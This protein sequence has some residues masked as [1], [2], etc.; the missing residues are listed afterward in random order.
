MT[1]ATGLYSRNQIANH[2]SSVLKLNQHV[3]SSLSSFSR[4]NYTDISLSYYDL[5]LRLQRSNV[6]FLLNESMQAL[7]P[8]EV[9]DGSVGGVSGNP[10]W[11]GVNSCLSFSS[12]D[13]LSYF[14]YAKSDFSIVNNSFT[15]VSPPIVLLKCNLGDFIDASNNFSFVSYDLSNG[16]FSL[17]QYSQGIN[18]SFLVNPDPSYLQIIDISFSAV[19]NALLHFDF[20]MFF[21]TQEYY[22]DISH[23]VIGY[24]FFDI[25]NTVDTVHDYLYDLN[26]NSVL[27]GLIFSQYLLSILI[28]VSLPLLTVRPKY[29]RNGNLNG[30]N[31]TFTMYHGN[32]SGSDFIVPFVSTASIVNVGGVDSYFY[33]ITDKT[34]LIQDITNSFNI[35]QAYNHYP[36]NGSSLS[37]GDTTNSGAPLYL[38]MNVSLFLSQNDFSVSLYDSITGLG[39]S[40]SWVTNFGFSS[41]PYPLE[42]YY[43]TG[44]TF[45]EI[46][47]SRIINV[48]DLYLDLT[49][50]FFYIRPFSNSNGLYTTVTGEYPGYYYNDIRIEIP[51]GYYN[52]SSLIAAMNQALASN[53]LTALSSFLYYPTNV[54]NNNPQYAVMKIL[55][56]KTFTAADYVLDF[57]DVN[58]FYKCY[59]LDESIRNTTWDTT[60]GWILGYRSIQY[61]LSNYS[62]SNGSS[63]FVAKIT[64]DV[65]VNVNLFSYFLITVDDFNQSRL[66]DGLVSITK[67]EN[68]IPLPNYSSQYEVVCPTKYGFKSGSTFVN[69]QNITL[70][71]LYASIQVQ[72]SLNTPISKSYSQGPFVKDIFGIIPLKT[73]GL[74]TGQVFSDYGGS[75][76][77][78]ERLY[79]GPVNIRRLK[80]QLFNNQ[81]NLVDLNGADWSFSFVCEQL[82]QINNA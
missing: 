44:N 55:V 33:T 2:F 46:T 71:K 1:L 48:T 7:F 47:G 34:V 22:V 63:H 38:N 30:N 72:N 80:I 24:L 18:R 74:Q 35:F 23:S 81:G 59:N 78:Q 50:N 43:V 42:Q 56:S 57:Y 76:Q 10:I 41:S 6:P 39:N 49:S 32:Y 40:S 73:A 25:N 13:S 4:I 54:V 14:N 52:T 51:V 19:T 60:L 82:Y 26:A 11:T 21:K 36:L 5:T 65:T 69:Q 66:N 29:K 68:D 64:G 37:F 8:T 31:A 70:N 12:D 62:A 77:Q 28:P 79:F 75:L 67:M 27:S 53:P 20:N 3:S 15:I 45:T 58:S 9:V 16:S 17:S 61:S